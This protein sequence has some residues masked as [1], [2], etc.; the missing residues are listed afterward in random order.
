M[1]SLGALAALHYY[2]TTSKQSGSEGQVDSQNN[3]MDALWGHNNPLVFRMDTE[4]NVRHDPQPSNFTPDIR[5]QQG[6]YQRVPYVGDVAVSDKDH[7]ALAHWRKYLHSADLPHT[8]YE[9]TRLNNNFRNSALTR[10]P[11]FIDWDAAIHIP[12]I[13]SRYDD[14]FEVKHGVTTQFHPPR[15]LTEHGY[16]NYDTGRVF[17]QPG[18]PDFYSWV[19]HNL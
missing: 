7:E 17:S 14:G 9:A 18:R 19:P 16:P 1:L 5:A 15:Y 13:P 10:T 6:Y 8:G 4:K 3:P 2:A 11:G 12:D